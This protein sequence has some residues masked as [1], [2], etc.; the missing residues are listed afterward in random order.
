[1]N[2]DISDRHEVETQRKPYHAPELITLGPIQS[3]INGSNKAGADCITHPGVMS[4][5]GS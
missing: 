1:M 5:T 2:F 3:A 4:K